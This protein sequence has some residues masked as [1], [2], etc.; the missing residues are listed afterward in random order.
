VKQKKLERNIERGFAK[1]G[2]TV[3]AKCP[4]NVT[5]V[6]GKTFYCRITSGGD[7][8][9]IRVTLKSNAAVGNLVWKLV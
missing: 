8:G 6:K 4:K 5:W 7:L 2:Y 9:R 3:T 1:Q